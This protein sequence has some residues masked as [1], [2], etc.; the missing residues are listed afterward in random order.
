MSAGETI[1]AIFARPSPMT[2]EDVEEL[3]AAIGE[4]MLE[5]A[6]A[7]FGRFD[8][9]NWREIV[10]LIEELE[11]G[12][13]AD[14]GPKPSDTFEGAEP[15]LAAPGLSLARLFVTEGDWPYT[16]LDAFPMIATLASAL[17]DHS[18][19]RS[20]WPDFEDESWV[21]YRP[22]ILALEAIEQI[23]ANIGP[24]EPQPVEQSA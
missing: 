23:A 18:L 4:E 22:V 5:D 15:D 11:N 8:D 12:V 14:V 1:T 7:R 24:P 17:L 16:A 10:Y 19:V 2:L 9:W 13:L 6:I 3:N 20:E 21:N